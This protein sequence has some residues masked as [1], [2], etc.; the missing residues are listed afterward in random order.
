MAAAEWQWVDLNRCFVYLRDSGYSSI[1]FPPFLSPPPPPPP[2]EVTVCYEGAHWIEI[3]SWKPV[4]WKS[5]GKE[6]RLPPG[7]AAEA[8]GQ[9]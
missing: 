7:S 5:S 2:P 1:L 9:G 4:G 8:A 3:G 6:S